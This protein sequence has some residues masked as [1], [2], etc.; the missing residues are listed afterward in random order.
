M[1]EPAALTYTAFLLPPSVVSR[2]DVSRLVTEAERV[3]NELTTA[4]VRSKTGIPE[5]AAPVLSEQLAAFLQLNQIN[6]DDSKLRSELVRQLRLLKD[7]VPVIHMAFAVTA[8]RESLE[9]LAAWLRQDVHPQTVIAVEL[10]PAL[11]GGVY[12]RTTNH[13]HDFSLRSLLHGRTGVI[14]TELEVLRAGS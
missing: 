5:Y 11:L 7:N 12:I 6:L 14:R 8:D 2:V 4:V 10:Q 3:D 13:I 1:N 9:Q